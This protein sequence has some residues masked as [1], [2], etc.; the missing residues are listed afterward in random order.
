M[1]LPAGLIDQ[2]TEMMVVNNDLICL[3]GGKV[4][5][6]EQLPTSVHYAIDLEMVRNGS[7]NATANL[8]NSLDAMVVRKQYAKCNFGGM[9]NNADITI[10]GTVVHEYVNCGKRGNCYY[11]GRVCKHIKVINGYLTPREIVYLKHLNLLNKEIAEAMNI[12]EETVPS[13]GKKIHEK[14]GLQTKAEQMAL[15]YQLGLIN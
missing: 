14:T 3:N 12:S 2:N 4:V 11:E 5:E 6:F 7:S 10:D 15:A 8:C 1:T 13:Y 9:D